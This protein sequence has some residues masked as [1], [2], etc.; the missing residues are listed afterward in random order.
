MQV[1]EEPYQT[2]NYCASDWQ[3]YVHLFAT[4][5]AAGEEEYFG[6]SPQQLQVRLERGDNSLGKNLIIIE[7]DSKMIGY[8]YMVPEGGIDRIVFYC[9]VHPSYRRKKIGI[10]L[11]HQGI[12]RA[13]TL[14]LSKVHVNIN[15]DNAAAKSFL[16][17]LGFRCV[18]KYLELQKKMVERHTEATDLPVGFYF[19][20]L[21]DGEEGILNRL[22]NK[23][24]RGSWGFN[25]HT[26]EDVIDW[27]HLS[28]GS[29]AD[30]ILAWWGEEPAGYCWTQMSREKGRGRIHMIGVEPKY[31]HKKLGKALLAKSLDYLEKKGMHTTVLTVDHHNKP[32]RNLYHNLGFKVMH[33][34]LWYEKKLD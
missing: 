11:F 17:R 21:Q 29:T 15:R 33:T 31:R 30:I 8:L 24:F 20:S 13:Y 7:K 6:L 18:R 32:A 12:K 3:G 19:R 14:G 23:A 22:Q 26:V 16:S 5:E 25:P 2:R 28:G 27:L 10:R 34:S 9:F 1:Q 4:A